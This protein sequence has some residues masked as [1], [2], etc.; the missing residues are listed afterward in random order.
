M[1]RFAGC[2]SQK[3][4][5]AD[6]H[7]PFPCREN[8]AGARTGR[9]MEM[10]APNRG[11]PAFWETEGTGWLFPE[12]GVASCISR[13]LAGFPGTD[14]EMPSAP[15]G[16]PAAGQ[17]GTQEFLLFP[18]RG[19]A[20]PGFPLRFSV[21]RTGQTGGAVSRFPEEGEE[22]ADTERMRQ[23]GTDRQY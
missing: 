13:R 22:S 10:G 9:K 15:D 20:G 3:T 17:A 18:A 5:R 11:S 6:E 21:G 2:L 16:V 8:P 7:F 12:A 23:N 4:G 1:R 14:R 19:R